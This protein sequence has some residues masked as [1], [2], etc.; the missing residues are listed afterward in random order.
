MNKYDFYISYEE[1][2]QLI[3]KFIDMDKPVS[4]NFINI[5]D[6]FKE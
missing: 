5:I 6:T 2:K 3:G 4:R 1:R